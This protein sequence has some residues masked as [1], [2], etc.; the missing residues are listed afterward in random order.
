MGPVEGA[1]TSS[2]PGVAVVVG[3]IIA[4]LIILLI[5]IDVSCYFVNGCGAL[6]TVCSHVHA[7]SPSNK[8]KMM[9]EGDR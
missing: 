4:V 8:D 6:A 7:S 2:G 1:S 9:E 5:A 3:V